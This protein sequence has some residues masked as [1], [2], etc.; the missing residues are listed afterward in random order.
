MTTIEQG[1]VVQQMDVGEEHY[2]DQVVS[3]GLTPGGPESYFS[4]G[5]ARAHSCLP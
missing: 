3:M 2:L 5:R 4:A 1:K